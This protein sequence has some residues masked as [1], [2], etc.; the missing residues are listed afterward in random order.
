MPWFLESAQLLKVDGLRDPTTGQY[1]NTA[2]IRATMYES[3]GTT[4]VAGQAWPLVLSYVSASNGNYNG[5]LQDDRVLVEGRVY[6]L[7]VEA[8]A[9]GDVIK[10]WRWHD[11]ARYRTPEDG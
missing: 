9:G 3:N 5:V 10:T 7:E 2:T 6:W 8:D 1:V 4:V 11:V